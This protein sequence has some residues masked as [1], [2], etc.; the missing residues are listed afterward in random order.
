MQETKIADPS[1]AFGIVGMVSV[2]I[3]MHTK[4]IDLRQTNI[5]MSAMRDYFPDKNAC[6]L[7]ELVYIL[8]DQMAELNAGKLPIDGLCADIGEHADNVG[9]NLKQRLNILRDAL[10][11]MLISG[12][13][14][15]K[16][17]YLFGALKHYMGI[18]NE[19][20]SG[21]D[22]MALAESCMSMKDSDCENSENIEAHEKLKR[23]LSRTNYELLR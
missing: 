22:I 9:L 1:L 7:R 18:S 21:E 5:I 15:D 8:T 16:V 12:T 17:A 11:L 4:S 2:L 6:S 20:A 23:A 19:I 13:K 14:D 3:L 10:A